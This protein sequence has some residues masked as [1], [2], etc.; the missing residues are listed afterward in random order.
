[1]QESS[2]DAKTRPSPK[3]A[4]RSARQKASLNHHTQAELQS[5][6]VQ[7]LDE[8][9]T[10]RNSMKRRGDLQGHSLSVEESHRV[11]SNIL[12]EEAE[13]CLQDHAQELAA[14]LEQ[15]GNTLDDENSLPEAA[16]RDLR[17][18]L[19]ADDQRLGEHVGRMEEEVRMLTRC[20][21]KF[22]SLLREFPVPLRD[23]RRRPVELDAQGC[24]TSCCSMT[25]GLATTSS[26]HDSVATKSRR[27][28]FGSLWRSSESGT[29]L[30]EEHKMRIH[31]TIT[32]T[33]TTA[34][35]K[36]VKIDVMPHDTATD[37]KEL[38]SS[39]LLLWCPPEVPPDQAVEESRLLF[40]GM[41]LKPFL[42][43]TSLGV[44]DG[45]V[46]RLIP[47]ISKSSLRCRDAYEASAP[48]GILMNPGA[49]PWEVTYQR[50]AEAQHALDIKNRGFEQTLPAIA[51]QK[52]GSGSCGSTLPAPR[53]PRSGT[54]DTVRIAAT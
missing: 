36:A 8:N 21:G 2:S 53:S 17:R 6:V 22:L 10:L 38:L 41:V 31:V 13:V 18:R 45:S 24:L 32:P 52:L 54:V 26:P 42:S 14:L 5:I 50:L 46:L 43:L 48:R 29:D 47:A 34:V 44:C 51:R 16:M 1:M 4:L 9:Q 33:T 40:N 35:P 20:R 7:L 25:S 28:T 27:P 49:R 39:S 37:V 3:S 30:F 11:T 19:E 23:T 15:Q 12:L